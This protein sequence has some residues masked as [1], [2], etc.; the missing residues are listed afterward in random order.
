MH[1]CVLYLCK[2]KN[3]NSF[4]IKLLNFCQNLNDIGP[5]HHKDLFMIMGEIN[6]IWPKA[7]N[8]RDLSP[9]YCNSQLEETFSDVLSLCNLNQFKSVQPYLQPKDLVHYITWHYSMER[10]FMY[11]YPRKSSW[12][13]VFILDKY[14]DELIPIKFSKPYARPKLNFQIPMLVIRM[15]LRTLL[16]GSVISLLLSFVRSSRFPSQINLLSSMTPLFMLFRE[17]QSV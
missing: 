14:R 5:S 16:K 6:V 8:S 10:N 17:Y 3:D 2:D 4:S 7:T 12:Y 15:S 13:I 9:L 1:L 11:R